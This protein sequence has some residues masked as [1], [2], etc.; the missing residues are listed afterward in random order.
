MVR[1]DAGLAAKL[2][3]AYEREPLLQAGMDLTPEMRRYLEQA[4]VEQA[5]A[6]DPDAG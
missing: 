2:F 3:A 1:D 6:L 4:A 5:A